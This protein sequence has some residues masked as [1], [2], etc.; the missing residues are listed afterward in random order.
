MCVT[1]GALTR[2]GTALCKATIDPLA[3]Y[4]SASGTVICLNDSFAR[5]LER[6]VDELYSESIHVILG[7]ESVD[8]IPSVLS[9]ARGS[10]SRVTVFP[11]T[12]QL[13]GERGITALFLQPTIISELQQRL[14][15]TY[16]AANQGLWDWDVRSNELIWS[17]RFIRMVGLDP[18]LFTPTLD[19]FLER[20]HPDDRDRVQ[21]ALSAHISEGRPYD[22]AYR[23]KHEAGHYI[24]VHAFGQAVWDPQGKP[25]RMVGSVDD[26][27]EQIATKAALTETEYRFQQMAE[28]IPGA[29]FRYILHPDGRDEMEYMSPGC[30]DIWEVEATA[31][32]HDASA[33]WAM[34]LEED[35]PDMQRSVMQSAQE[36]KPWNHRWR[37]RTPSGKTKWL[38]GRGLPT[39]QDN[40]S[41]LWN[42]LIL[43]VTEQFE[44]EAELQ[45]SRELFHRAQKTE[46]LGQLTGG[47]AHDFNNLLTVVLGNLELINTSGDPEKRQAYVSDALRAVKHG[48][49]LTQSLLAFARRAT[50]QP[51]PLTMDSVLSD[52][53]T[54]LRRTLPS[55]IDFRIRTDDGLPTLT[56]DR[57][58][59]ESALLNLVINARD[60]VGDD[61][62]IEVVF[63]SRRIVSKNE[64]GLPSGDYVE[65]EVNDNGS[66]MPQEFLD[67]VLEPFFTTKGEGSGTG[68]GLSIVDGFV[69]Q[70]GGTMI[71]DSEEGKGT[72]V[73]LLFPASAEPAASAIDVTRHTPDEVGDGEDAA[74]TGTILV[75]ED[76]PAVRHVIT[77]N[78]LAHGYEVIQAENGDAGRQLFD[79]QR[80]AISAVLTDYVM[81]GELHGG[82]L[83]RYIKSVSPETPVVLLSGYVDLDKF[84]DDN[85][86]AAAAD[87]RLDKPVERDVLVRTIGRLLAK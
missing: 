17:D 53:E 54:L 50:L 86:Q 56:L 55:S 76:E 61:G 43:D 64:V 74:T 16:A 19:T 48:K 81:P 58:A 1:P 83:A 72:C 70:S 31:I 49:E 41:V 9:L 2:A 40:G 26:I 62:R 52:L 69:R 3:I 44:M 59:F 5:M 30:L 10:G 37:I 18:E 77:Q 85:D 14:D 78:L 73:C 28:N 60:A 51:E 42:S 15:L 32:E 75:V 57:A 8:D 39:R 80:D 68:L 71:I 25:V 29:I 4:E 24:H 33:V 47:L 67:R 13:D 34:V 46:S 11:K 87:A 12:V 22:I 82:A 7:R 63:R 6:P 65:I 36:L 35:L 23:L 84:D 20:L 66:G 38:H 27:S 79:A 45:R 21:Q